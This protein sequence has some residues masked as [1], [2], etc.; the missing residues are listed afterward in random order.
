M[1]FRRTVLRKV[2]EYIN[3]K[4]Y[5]ANINVI[6]PSRGKYQKPPTIKEILLE[7]DVFSEE[8]Y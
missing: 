5:P 2:N 4:L 3:G 8:Y 7:L 1:N 6:D